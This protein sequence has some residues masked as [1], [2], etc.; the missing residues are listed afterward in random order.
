MRGLR[1]ASTGWYQDSF[2]VQCSHRIGGMALGHHIAC[3]A[4]AAAALGANA[5][6][7]LDFVKTHA[8]TGVA[9]DFTVGNSAADTNNHGGRQW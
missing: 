6:F 5:Q 1:S 3:A 4:F 9:G 8:G 7:K 2:V